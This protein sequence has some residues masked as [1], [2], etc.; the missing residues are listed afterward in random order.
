MKKAISVF[1][2]VTLVGFFS[3]K[4]S[5]TGGGGGGG[6]TEDTTTVQPQVDPA[7]ANTIGFFLDDWQAKSFTAP[8]GFQPSSVP[9][10][11][12]VTVT[13]DRSV[14]IT[15]IPR[16]LASDNSNLWMGQI[17][18]ESSLMDHITTLHPH[19]IRFPGGSISDVFFWNALKD[20]KPADAPDQLV[21]DNGTSTAAGYWY[22][23]NAENW[24]FS[25]E[26]YYN[27]LQQTGNAGMIV[28][29]YGYA[30]YGT[31]PNPAAAA[32]HLA[33]DWVRF[34]NGRT[35]YW[36]IGNE[37]YGNWEAGYRI[38]T[39]NN[40]DGQP[41]FLTG[42]LYGQHFKIFA[43]SMR[44][45]ANEIGK[46]IYLG[47]VTSESAPQTW[48]SNTA[49]GWNSGLFTAAGNSPD[50]HI[51]HNYYTPFQTNADADVI[52]NTPITETATMTDYVKAQ[53]TGAGLTQKPIAMTEWNITSQG[54]MQQV[55]NVNG[56]HAVMVIGE[57]LKNKLGMTARWD[58]AN[59]WSNGNDHGLFN[60]G[61]EPDGVPKWNPRPAYYH[62]Y[63][64]K[65][66]LGDRLVSS[67]SSNA[68]VISYASSFT[69][70]ET[71]VAL[72]NK[73]STAA[74]VEVNI[75]NFK[76]GSKFYFYT[77]TGGTD[78]GSFSRKVLVNGATTTYAAGGPANY[79]DIL[80]YS[81]STNSGI[82][83]SIPARSA[84]YLVVTKQ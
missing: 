73:G 82:R 5:T 70:G 18:T 77:L 16:S 58:M 61:D 44:K 76:K 45:A 57:S 68:N 79:K 60:Q 64:F 75:K 24:T 47:A 78:N 51:V 42:Q 2:I 29:N 11:A 49:K 67:T 62:M 8:S 84:V 4:K 21:Q 55:S 74:T 46:T 52:L 22:G 36:E 81:A 40:K 53:I 30:R 72:V 14:V 38:N 15:K 83:L 32:A 65:K 43:D 71:G 41:E 3:C 63:F 66:Y 26:N 31:G 59:G 20:Q 54:Q 19:I 28:V 13:V 48:W 6:T 80:P 69:S 10:A 39:A 12:G 25:V 17:V 34:D 37:N 1:M 33:A 56:L 23:K 27:M 9:A 50:F 7:T 35:K